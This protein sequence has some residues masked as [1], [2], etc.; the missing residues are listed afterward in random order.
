MRGEAALSPFSSPVA[1]SKS[2]FFV[3]KEGGDSL[4]QASPPVPLSPA[5][6][7]PDAGAGGQ[8]WAGSPLPPQCLVSPGP[9]RPPCCGRVRAPGV[10]GAEMLSLWLRGL[11]GRILFPRC[12]WATWREGREDGGGTFSPV[13]V[14]LPAP[15]VTQ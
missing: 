6:P 13:S 11:H 12:H 14:S 3:Q 5:P 8:L 2:S 1:G 10:G 4:L 7:R 9:L 15:G